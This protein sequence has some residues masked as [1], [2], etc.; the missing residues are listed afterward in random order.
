MKID[1]FV[2]LPHSIYITQPLDVGCFQPFKHYYTE[3]IDSA[4]RL[5]S[6]DFNRLNFLVAFN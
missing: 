2:L 3:A 1:L 6:S 4:V 5:D